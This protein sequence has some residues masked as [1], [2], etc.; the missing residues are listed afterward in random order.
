[1]PLTA[2]I[3]ESERDKFTAELAAL[4]RVS[5][6]FASLEHSAAVPCKNGTRLAVMLTISRRIAVT[7]SVTTLVLRQL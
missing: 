2:L 5:S 6:D 7:R 1:M 4:E 3:H